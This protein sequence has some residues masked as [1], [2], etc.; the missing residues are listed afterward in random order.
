MSLCFPW[1]YH[2]ACTGNGHYDW[3]YKEMVKRYGEP[4]SMVDF[5]DKMQ[6]MNA[7]GYQGIFEA[8]GHKLNEIG[9]VMLWK[10]NAAFPSVVWQVI[11]WYNEPN[12][13]YY[14][15]QNALETVHVQLNALDYNVTVLNRTYQLVSKLTVT[16]DVFDLNSKLLSHE[17]KEVSLAA[18]DVQELFSVSKVLTD[19]RDVNF[20]V[21]NLKDAKGKVVSHNT[22]WLASDNNYKSL[23]ELP[24]TKVQSTIL[25]SEKGKNETTWTVKFANPSKQLA[26]F[27][28]PQLLVEG[29]EVLPSYWSANY[30]S[31]APGE[32]LT[33][34]IAVSTSQLNGNNPELLVEGWNVDRVKI[35]VLLK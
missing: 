25:K 28:H 26:F 4:T 6:L 30:F 35:P 24:K 8:A 13:G 31:L 7:T 33:T 2:D 9:G 15:M 23:S 5:S 22:Y 11:D 27:V 16:A 19:N 34:T 21:L 29:T 18:T 32:T 12:A 20:V 1:G 10:L 14:F 3:Y 17:A